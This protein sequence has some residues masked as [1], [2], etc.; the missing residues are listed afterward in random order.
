MGVLASV[1]AGVHGLLALQ[2]ELRTA[3]KTMAELRAQL[4]LAQSQVWP[5]RST[6]EGP[7]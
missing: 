6:A 3:E 1:C 7:L 2:T 5:H 4:A